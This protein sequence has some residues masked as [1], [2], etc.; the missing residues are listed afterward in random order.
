M[1]RNAILALLLISA[2]RLFAADP[3]AGPIT[4]AH[5]LELFRA[6]SPA[7]AAA[8]AHYEAVQAGEVTAR[9]R[10]NPVANFANEDFNVFHPALFDIANAQ[11]FTD[12]LSWTIERGGKRP[13][14]IA[15]A[16]W[17]TTVAGHQ[18]RD[19][20][21]QLELQLKTA[22][23]SVLQG[24]AVLKLAQDNLADYQRVLNANQLRLQA[25]D[26][27][28][29]DFDRIKLQEAS[30]QSDLLNAES[31]LTQARAQLEALLGLRPAGLL[32]VTGTLELPVLT[33]SVT[34]L[35]ERAL[36][37]RPDYLAA[38]AGISKAD[39]DYRLAVANGITDLNLAPEYKR[40]GPDNTLGITLQLPVRIF[41]RNQGE[42]LRTSHELTSSRFTENAARLQAM[43]DVAQSFQAY[44]AA[45]ARARLYTTDYLVRARKVRDAV[46]FSYEH[47]N[48]NLLD[49]L[50]AVR[51]YR[52]V[53]LAAVNAE[54]QVWLAI[55][56]LSAATGTE[57]AP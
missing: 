33:L 49:F 23:V 11:E 12:S 17:G 30:F 16:Q 19:N 18:Y 42:K 57:V 20:Q 34:E 8:R 50:D 35:Q 13:A 27:S 22:F 43:A 54:A 2:C 45:D 28:Q 44:S 1:K 47:G 26:I 46:R 7:L 40:N 9:L 15:S 39:A 6:N 48:T 14:R 53:E 29:T 32:D 55:H 25:G 5:A 52:E 10:P 37:N 41:D 51:S 36:A 56:Q 4:L 31:A 38:R 3:P 21:R 24:K